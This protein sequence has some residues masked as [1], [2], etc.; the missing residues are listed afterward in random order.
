MKSWTNPYVRRLKKQ[1][2]LRMSPDAV[3]YFKK[4]AEETHILHQSLINLYPDELLC[5]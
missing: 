4:V 1:V 5:I 3:E 2:T